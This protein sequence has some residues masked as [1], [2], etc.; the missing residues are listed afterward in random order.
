M[1][2]MLIRPSKGDNKKAFDQGSNTLIS[3]QN[4]KASHHIQNRAGSVPYVE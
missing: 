1:T 3:T 2:A 4:D